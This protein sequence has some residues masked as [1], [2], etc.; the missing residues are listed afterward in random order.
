LA[1][2]DVV[3]HNEPAKAATAFDELASMMTDEDYAEYLEMV[4]EDLRG[5][6][7]AVINVES[8]P[9]EAPEVTVRVAAKLYDEVEVTVYPVDPKKY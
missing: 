5:P 6:A 2:Y 1:H 8:N 7:L 9:R 3:Y 4:A